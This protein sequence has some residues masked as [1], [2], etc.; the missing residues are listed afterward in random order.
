MN[1]FLG[2][3]CALLVGCALILFLMHKSKQ[4]QIIKLEKEVVTAL[5]EKNKAIAEY[6]V[7]LSA[8]K[9][10]LETKA[11]IEKIKNESAVVE[12]EVKESESQMQ[13]YNSIVEGFNR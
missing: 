6:D 5:N 2:S 12:T 4:K 10:K 3:L 9:S 11:E 1:Y 8:L 7:K 13:S